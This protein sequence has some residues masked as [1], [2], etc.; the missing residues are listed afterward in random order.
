MYSSDARADYELAC[1]LDRIGRGERVKYQSC[2]SGGF[3]AIIITAG[4]RCQPT[5]VPQRIDNVACCTVCRWGMIPREVEI[6]PRATGLAI[7]ISTCLGHSVFQ[8][9]KQNAMC[10]TG[11]YKQYIA[12]WNSKHS[13]ANYSC[14]L[15]IMECCQTDGIVQIILLQP[16]AAVLCTY[17]LSLHADRHGGDIS[18]TVCL[19]VRRIFGNTYLGRGL[20]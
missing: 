1:Y 16:T 3:H 17:L 8:L 6:L 2:D 13:H 19:C 4:K 7:N 15:L 12:Y 10:Q 14:H 20:M 9:L 5:L 11:P 18:F